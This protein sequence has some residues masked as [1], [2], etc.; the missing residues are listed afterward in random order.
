MLIILFL[1]PVYHESGGLVLARTLCVVQKVQILPTHV[2]SACLSQIGTHIARLILSAVILQY[3]FVIS[4]KYV[5]C[6]DDLDRRK[7]LSDG[8]RAMCIRYRV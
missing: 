4:G 8:K 2:N 7:Q 3:Q 1:M 6:R 5:D